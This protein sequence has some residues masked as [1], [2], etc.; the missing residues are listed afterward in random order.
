M[1]SQDETV[2]HHLV[3]QKLQQLKQAY[4]AQGGQDL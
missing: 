4:I 3:Q 2:N 1:P